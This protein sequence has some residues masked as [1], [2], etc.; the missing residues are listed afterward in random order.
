MQTYVNLYRQK[1]I[2]RGETLSSPEEII[3]G[4]V[5]G[6]LRCYDV[7]Q[8]QLVTDQLL[9][10]IGS[11]SVSNDGQCLLVATLDSQIRLLEHSDGSELT[12][13]TGHTNKRVKVQSALDPTDSFVASGS[14]DAQ[15]EK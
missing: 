1:H 15:L 7:R 13:Y 11:V 3:S 5:D 2:C 14:E 6:G 10:P 9:Q 12:S 8:G 4:S